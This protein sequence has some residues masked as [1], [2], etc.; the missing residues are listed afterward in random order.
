MTKDI[1]EIFSNNLNKYISQKGVTV[2]DV[3]RETGIA[4]QTVSD[5]RN[6]KAMARGGGLQR[7]ADYFDVNI[8]DL[9]A[10]KPRNI[11]PITEL[12]RI[13]ILG[14]IACG[15]PI[16]A[17]ENVTEYR[18]VPKDYLPTGEL[19]FLEAQGD[20]ME[21]K[22]S[23]GSY[24]LCRKQEDVESGEIAAVLVNGDQETTLKKVIKQG[25]TIL[26][27][28]LNEA[29]APYI[30]TNDNPARIVGKALRVENEL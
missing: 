14:T 18:S 15:D 7:L 16:D 10:D 13:P 28:A 19:F 20:S 3:A 2:A 9:T 24:V 23:N 5:W 4:Y 30:I 17:I 25:E 6:G 12:V 26:L 21:P 22:I 11:M 8:S 1:K 27:Q 29:Y